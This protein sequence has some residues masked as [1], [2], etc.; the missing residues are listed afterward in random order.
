MA[1]MSM[2]KMTSYLCVVNIAFAH[3]NAE[4]I[5]NV[6]DKMT[7]I[8]LMFRHQNKTYKQIFL[9]KFVKIKHVTFKYLKT[10]LKISKMVF[11]Y[12]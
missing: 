2:V 3:S 12:F 4:G 11:R 6:I 9:S 7:N 5:T 10:I 1:V 8:L